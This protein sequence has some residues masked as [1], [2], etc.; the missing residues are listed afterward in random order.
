M[1]NTPTPQRPQKQGPRPRLSAMNKTESGALGSGGVDRWTALNQLKQHRRE[2][3]LTP[4]DISVVEALLKCVERGPLMKG[5]AYWIHASNRKLRTLSGWSQSTLTRSLRLLVNRK[6]IIRHI[7]GSGK[8]QSSCASGHCYLDASAI[9]ISPMV[10][11]FI[12]LPQKVEAFRQDGELQKEMRSAIKHLRSEIRH[13]LGQFDDLTKPGVKNV[14][15]RFCGDYRLPRKS[16]RFALQ[17]TLAQHIK[18]RDALVLILGSS[19][20]YF[21]APIQKS[22]SDVINT[23][24]SLGVDGSEE[25]PTEQSN[26]CVSMPIQR[27]IEPL[28]VVRLCPELRDYVVG[29]HVDEGSLYRAANI[30]R[31]IFTVS[32]GVWEGA[33]KKAGAMAAILAVAI[34]LRRQGSLEKHG[35]YLAKILRNVGF[36]LQDAQSLFLKLVKYG[37]QS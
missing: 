28:V 31:Q 30:I 22:D 29:P 16:S 13:L 11:W 24:S 35:A 10:E 14:A 20:A 8:R 34:V 33:I 7:S 1:K 6:L 9:D 5:K 19:G 18:D 25:V 3:G 27:P 15:Q 21:E 23:T 12:S 17:N 4:S 26:A 32:D 2:F 37:E 36:G